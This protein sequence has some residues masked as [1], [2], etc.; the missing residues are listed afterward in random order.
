MNHQ[1]MFQNLNEE[2]L[3]SRNYISSFDGDYTT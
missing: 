1:E 3:L 2:S